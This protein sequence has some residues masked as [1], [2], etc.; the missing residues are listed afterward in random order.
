MRPV[1]FE[2]G[3]IKVYSYYVLWTFALCLAVFLTRRRM[4]DLYGLSDDD[5][6][7]IIAFS[8][9][10]MLLGARAGTAVEFW[11]MYSA[12]P[13]RLLRFWEGGLSA[14]PA[15]LGA[16]AAG[17]AA[18]WKRGIPLWVTADSAAVPAAFT[19]ALG[20][21][22]CFLNGCCGG[23]E[24]SVPWAVT[25]PG[26]PSAALRHPTQLYYAFGAL[27]IGAA[28]QWTEQ[29]HLSFG[30]DRRIRGAVLWPLF[31]VF[32]ALLRIVAD[33]FRAEYETAG[34]RGTRYILFAVLFFGALWVVFSL[35][36]RRERRKC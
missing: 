17:I 18:S 15:F 19:V 32:Y 30:R 21:W 13:W 36:F 28:L 12:E 16:G 10:G 4:T 20:R 9:A 14:V 6:R 5:A 26:D 27:F 8:F 34:L 24:T 7:V 33:P 2:F 29:N 11:Q 3:G 22:G 35:L 1:L 23:T 25:F 31:M